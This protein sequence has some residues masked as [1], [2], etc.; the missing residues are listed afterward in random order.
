MKTLKKTLKLIKNLFRKP[1]YSLVYT[2]KDGRTAMYTISKPE[3]AHEFG[4]MKE[5]LHT[6]GFR[7]FC[8]NRGGFRSFRYDRIISLTR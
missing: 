4:N 1:L 3:H 6:A 7:A 8:Y 5:G 2:T